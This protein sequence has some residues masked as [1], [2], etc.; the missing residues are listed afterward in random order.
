MT[1]YCNFLKH[2]W[3]PLFSACMITASIIMAE[4]TVAPKAHCIASDV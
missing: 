1:I 2:T 3:T 4:A